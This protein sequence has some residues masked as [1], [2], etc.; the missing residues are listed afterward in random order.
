MH[1]KRTISLG[2]IGLAILALASVLAATASSAGSGQTVVKVMTIGYPDK[3]TTDP[4]TGAKVPGIG[5]LQ[6]EFEQANPSIDLQIINVPWGSGS[7]SY[8]AKTDAM[9]KSN[10]ACIYEMPDA[11]TYGREGDLVNLNTLI[12]SDP[13]WK[14]VWGDAITSD[15]SWGPSSPH[16]LFYLP[17]NTGIRVVNWDAQIFKDYGVPPLSQHPTLAEIARDAAKMTGKDPVTGQETYGY[18]YQGQYAVW[19]FM[20]IGDAMGATWGHANANGTLTINWNTP[21]YL[22][23]LKWFVKMSKY[24]PKGAL[25]SD[26]MPNGFL[27]N[28]N[29]VA[30]IPEGEQDYFIPQLTA[31]PTLGNRFRTSY[32]L[33]GPNGHGGLN[34]VSPLAMAASCNDKPAAWTALKWLAGSPQAEQYYFASDGRLPATTGS[35]N[36]IPALAKIKDVKA[37]LGQVQQADPPYPWASDDPR[38]DLQT[39]LEGALAGTLT[40]QQALQ[41]AQKKTA[42]WLAQQKPA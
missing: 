4:V 3:T 39:A 41:Q 33:K 12:A 10:G 27:T 36:L 2:A 31:D 17:D 18:W 21:K 35:A 15:T 32:N 30:I 34:A 25:A 5:E 13:H 24:A 37:I 42:Q 29:V 19:Q 22:A 11:Q 38:W 16:S 14:N 40:P 6:S 1:R 8:S 9:I 28:Q 7:T 26:T 20:A 23:A